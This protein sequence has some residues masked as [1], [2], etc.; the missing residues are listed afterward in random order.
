ME[1][2]IKQI[3]ITIVICFGIILLL[4]SVIKSKYMV[5][6]KVAS[7]NLEIFLDANYGNTLTYSDLNRFF[8]SGNMNPN[9]FRALVFEKEN[10]R[11]ELM[12]TFDAKEIITQTDIP[13][14]YPDGMTFNES[15][16]ERIL[17]VQIQNEISRKMK[18]LDLDLEWDYD[19]VTFTL[20]KVETEA[21]ILYKENLFLKLLNKEK[22]DILGYYHDLTLVLKPFQNTNVYLERSLE[23][24]DS[25][26]S[27][28]DLKLYKNTKG[29]NALKKAIEKG[30]YNYLQANYPKQRLY[31]YS[32]SFIDPT[33]FNKVLFIQATEI[34]KTQ[35]EEDALKKG[36]WTSP[37][38]GYV[39]TYWDLS[40]KRAQY[41]HFVITP[42]P[43]SMAESIDV[44]KD[45][46]LMTSW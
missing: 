24:K 28:K 14:A 8:N 6:K 17:A 4:L 23:Q 11:V 26:W 22:T 1:I 20:N 5:S 46:F 42:N 18:P 36:V 12:I 9:C 30:K 41:I 2:G 3:G 43:L 27:L 16:Q 39:V 40:K 19:K 45:S 32:E 37:I 44:E 35:K 7:K 10:P 15:Y 29:F 33:N 13:S 31:D 38:T 25:V 21:D 34:K